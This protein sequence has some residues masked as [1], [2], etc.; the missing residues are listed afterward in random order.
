MSIFLSC[1]TLLLLGGCR[2]SGGFQRNSAKFKLPVDRRV[3][4][5]IF[6]GPFSGWREIFSLKC[7]WLWLPEI[8]PHISNIREGKIRTKKESCWLSNVNNSLN[9]L[10]VCGLC[11]WKNLWTTYFPLFRFTWFDSSPLF[12]F[13]LLA[14]NHLHLSPQWTSDR[15]I[16]VF[17]FSAV[18]NLTHFGRSFRINK[19]ESYKNCPLRAVLK[20]N[21]SIIPVTL[22]AY[23]VDLK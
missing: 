13:N 11:D 17:F 6:K 4:T 23:Q 1:L 8:R 9:F 10:F 19:L 14:F 20:S 15:I 18:T 12:P 7:P 22:W 5:L 2:M 21:G 16:S 3:Q